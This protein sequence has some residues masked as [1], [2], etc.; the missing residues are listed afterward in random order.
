MSDEPE[1]PNRQRWGRLQW[2]TLAFLCYVWGWLILWGVARLDLLPRSN[3]FR[4]IA[5]IVYLPII[6]LEWLIDMFR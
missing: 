1:K 3:V 2:G 5:S 4:G 6:A